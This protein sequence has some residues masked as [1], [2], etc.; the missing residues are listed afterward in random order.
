M[1]ILACGASVFNIILSLFKM[2]DTPSYCWHYYYDNFTLHY[3]ETCQSIEVSYGLLFIRTQR[4]GP[5]QER[6]RGFCC[7]AHFFTR[8]FFFLML[9]KPSFFIQPKHNLCK[10]FFLFP[11]T[12]RPVPLLC[13]ERGHSGHS[14][15]HLRHP[16][17]LLLQ[18]GQLLLASSQN[19]ELPPDDCDI[20]LVT[21]AGSIMEVLYI[22]C[23][24]T[25]A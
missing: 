2:E 21:K 16:G 24:T 22:T 13:W 12:E 8:F 25:N 9:F 3:G 5:N 10:C 7:N 15:C 4:V 1:Q 11:L 20:N 17:C 23:W 6:N 18:G 19:G 14:G